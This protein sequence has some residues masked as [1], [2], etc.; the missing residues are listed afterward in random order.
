VTLGGWLLL[1]CLGLTL[2]AWRLE[3]RTSNLDLVDP[4]LPPVAAFRDFAD[5]FGTPNVLVVVFEGGTDRAARERAV[6]RAL[7]HLV[8]APGVSRVLARLPVEPLPFELLPAALAG[9]DPYLASRDGGLLYA[10]VQPDDPHSS[11][12]TIAPFVAAV[13]RA[14]AD[15]HLAELGVV[16]GLTGL[17]RYALDDRDVIQHDV[18]RLSLVSFVLVL[19]LF[20]VAFGSFAR[21]LAGMLTLALAVSATLGVVAFLPGHLTLVSAFFASILFG[22]GIDAAI[23]LVD[24]VEEMLGD[25][26]EPARLET[27]VPAAVAALE[28]GLTTGALTTASAFLTL[29]VSG[30]RGF[31]ELGWI[32][33][34]GILVCL[35]A[36]V[37]ALPALLVLAGRRPRH[38]SK[39]RT[40][41]GLAALDR[42]RLAAPLAALLAVVALA[43]YAAGPPAFDV[44]YLA[45]QPR[46]SEAVRLEREMVRRSD[47]SPQ[48]AAFVVADAAAEQALVERL[49]DEPTVA[50]VRSAADLDALAAAGLA[51]PADLA[52]WRRAFVADDGRRAVYAYP[53]GDVWQAGF[54]ERFLAAMQRLDPRVTGMPVLGRFMIDRSRHALHVTAIAGSL[55]LA[56]WLLADLR[57]PLL[58]LVAALPTILGVG[59]LFAAMRWTGVT[60]N[61]LDVMALPVVLGIAVDDGVHLVHRWRAEGGDVAR[62]LA[63]TGRSVLLTSLT[64]IAAFGSLAFTRHRGL[65]SFAL[66]LG[67][68]VGAALVVSLFVLPPLLARL[69]RRFVS[70]P[71]IGHT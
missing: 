41:R 53:D 12:A 61:P 59:A 26:G 56:F 50:A 16:T 7:P 60:F 15:A 54:Q 9:F 64:S 33:A 3:L 71:P 21:P 20:A 38:R 36:T 55:C 4:E 8:A 22:L 35:L 27:V 46:G 25:G 19:A 1:A 43:G 69:P 14:L 6:D 66:V 47:L 34:A 5:A 17:P 40:G 48:F 29:L 65:A 13:E 11:A 23:H 37:S 52:D 62:T 39:R 49:R 24:R 51:R 44:D 67:L 32:A 70:P 18:S 63:G 28:P 10:F 58:A 30:F 68:G 45:L 42:Q 31:A 2:A 57:R